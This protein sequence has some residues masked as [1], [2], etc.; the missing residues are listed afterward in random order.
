MNEML[1]DNQ[2]FV[3]LNPTDYNRGWNGE[4]KFVENA[5]SWWRTREIQEF[6]D[7]QIELAGRGLAYRPAVM[8][9]V[10]EQLTEGSNKGKWV[11]RIDLKT[12]TLEIQ[13]D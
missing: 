4:D 9:L 3:F 13:N 8:T 11:L 1:E 12:V 6:G 10:A 5:E 2:C 7:K